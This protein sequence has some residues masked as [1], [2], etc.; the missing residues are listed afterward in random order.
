[1][2]HPAGCLH[3]E[4]NKLIERRL[5]AGEKVDVTD[6]T[7]KIAESLFA[8]EPEGSRQ[9]AGA[10]D[11]AS[12]RDHL[13]KKR[14]VRRR[15]DTLNLSGNCPLHETRLQFDSLHFSMA[16]TGLGPCDP[17]VSRQGTW[18]PEFPTEFPRGRAYELVALNAPQLAHR[19]VRPKT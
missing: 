9:I 17:P 10:Y 19:I 5:Q 7:A 2:D 18:L 15:Y 3:C 13:A 14:G 4:V 1:M 16:M 8:A 6:M 11:R 12:G